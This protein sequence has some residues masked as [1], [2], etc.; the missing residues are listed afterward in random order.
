MQ[1]REW[2][3]KT[4]QEPGKLR[5]KHP[6]ACTCKDCTNKRLDK[7]WPTERNTFGEGIAVEV[8]SERSIGVL[9]AARN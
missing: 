8:E 4:W 7:T 3:E 6:A 1:E 2:K 9:R 5:H